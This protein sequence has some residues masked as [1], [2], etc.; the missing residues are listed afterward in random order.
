M[1][2]YILGLMSLMVLA[3]ASCSKEEGVVPG[4]DSNPCVTLYQLPVSMPLSAD[5]DA[6]IRV[7]ANSKVSEVYYKMYTE[8]EYES[9]QGDPALGEQIKSSG[10]KVELGVDKVYGGN[11][12]EFL[13]K[14]IMGKVVIAVAGV[15]GSNISVA[16]TEFKGLIW[17]DICEGS[18]MFAASFA[19]LNDWFKTPRTAILQ[20]C[21]NDPGLYRIKDLFGEGYGHKFYATGIMDED[22]DG[23]EF[24]YVYFPGSPTPFSYGNYGQI[25]ARDVFSWQGGNETYLVDMMY[26]DGYLVIWSQYY[27]AAGSLGY[28]YEYFIPNE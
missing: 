16:T 25:S 4:G 23:D 1:K 15:S 12:G 7:C 24:E 20:K 14:N 8:A 18:Y 5:N 2:K 21:E 3:L 9:V 26:P 17:S 28:A 27:V 22:K 19:S 13:I 10:T 6:C 11:D